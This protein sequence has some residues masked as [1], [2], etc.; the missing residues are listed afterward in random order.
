MDMGSLIGE[1]YMTAG[2][3]V[4]SGPTWSTRSLLCT[5]ATGS[6]L[7]SEGCCSL[8][9]PYF[10]GQHSSC[11]CPYR[12]LPQSLSL[13]HPSPRPEGDGQV[14]RL[15]KLKKPVGSLG[16]SNVPKIIVAAGSPYP[17]PMTMD[18]KCERNRTVRSQPQNQ[19]RNE[20][21]PCQC[22]LGLI[23]IHKLA[24]TDSRT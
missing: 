17:P 4:A 15:D 21:D 22:P 1:R 11:Q 5:P 18:T 20:N 24:P 10:Q 6:S 14:L 12:H 19:Y 2:N 23:A 9:R 3:S 16:P 7:N 8:C 13:S